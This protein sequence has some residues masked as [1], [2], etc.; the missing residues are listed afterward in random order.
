MD[1]ELR[2]TQLDVLKVFAQHTKTFAL[3]GGTALEL[4]YLHQA[5]RKYG[6]IL[7][8]QRALSLGSSS[9]SWRM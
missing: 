4:Y 3:A 7:Y 6:S 1:K 9:I 8:L 5:M 2:K